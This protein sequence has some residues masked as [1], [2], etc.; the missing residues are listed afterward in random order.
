MISFVEPFDIRFYSYIVIELVGIVAIIYCLRYYRLLASRNYIYLAI[1]FLSEVSFACIRMLRFYTEYNDFYLNK[2]PHYFEIRYIQ[3]INQFIW[4]VHLIIFVYL[5]MELLEWRKLKLIFRIPLLLFLI[6]TI[7]VAF[8]YE[9]STI[10]TTTHNIFGAYTLKEWWLNIWFTHFLFPAEK[11][12]LAVDFHLALVYLLFAFATWKAK[13]VSVNKIHRLPQYSWIG[14]G[15]A[16]SF[17]W[18]AY[19]FYQELTSYDAELSQLFFDSM[20]YL[21][22]IAYFLIM[23][24]LIFY[25]GMILISQAMLIEASKLYNFVLKDKNHGIVKSRLDRFNPTKRIAIYVQSLPS[26]IKELI[27]SEKKSGN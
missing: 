9:L 13:I 14:F 23:V 25:P 8:Y 3:Y 4:V 18:I 20:A 5:A 2:D 16:Q 11:P 24:I 15:L 7:L 19:M 12:I 6:E 17:S 26:E 1:I 27:L 22:I 10:Y 21:Q